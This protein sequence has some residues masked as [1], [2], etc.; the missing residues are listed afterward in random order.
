MGSATPDLE[1]RYLA[2]QGRYEYFSLPGRF[3][4][5]NLPTVEIIDM[6]K[7][8]REGN[9]GSISRALFDELLN[10]LRRGE[11]SIL[12]LNRRGTNK[13][14]ACVDCGAAYSCHR[15]SVSLT[16]HSDKN[17]LI[18][19]YCGYSQ[20][21]D[22]KCPDCGGGLSYIGYG[23]QKVVEELSELFPATEILRM[24]ADTIMPSRSHESLLT[25]FREKKTPILVG[26]QMVTKGLNFENVTLIGVISAD[27]SLYNGDFRS[28]E[29]T[30]SLITQVVGRSGRGSKPGRAVIQTFSPENQ[31]IM[32]AASQDYES[33]FD[34]ELSLRELSGSPPFTDLCSLTVTGSNESSVL[35]CCHKIRDLLSS[36]ELSHGA[37][38]LGP[39]PLSV[40]RV[41]NKYRY[42]VILA[43]RAS[44]EVYILLSGLLGYFGTSSEY[45]DVSVHAEINPSE[46]SR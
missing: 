13:L 44:R 18:C 30:F 37:R 25:E 9:G 5:Q 26:T 23:T 39:A 15:C 27:Q 43:R 20:R 14:I 21:P 40:V 1:S 11:Q 32:L 12:F 42:R 3:N 10:N 7:E 36:S 28:S 19:H 16:Y 29:R 45:R 22:E 34:S 35:R 46:N 33:F 24:D 41:K 8:L 38:V 31:T 6:K 17:R 2:A 4:N